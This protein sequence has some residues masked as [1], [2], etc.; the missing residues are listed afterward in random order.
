VTKEK[1]VIEEKYTLGVQQQKKSKGLSVGR[2][3]KVF[4]LGLRKPT[5]GGRGGRKET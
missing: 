1:G 3:S 4:Y 5:L 2:V